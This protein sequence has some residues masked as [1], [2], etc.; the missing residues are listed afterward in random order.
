MSRIIIWFPSEYTDYSNLYYYKGLVFLVIIYVNTFHHFFSRWSEYYFIIYENYFKF[1]YHYFIYCKYF[2]NFLD[3]NL[4]IYYYLDFCF[5]FSF[6]FSFKDKGS[7]IH[8]YWVILTWIFFNPSKGKIV[9]Y[10]FTGIVSLTFSLL[11][12][13]FFLTVFVWMQN[14]KGIVFLYI[15][16]LTEKN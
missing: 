5:Y 1:T 6:Y 9:V 8:I 16:L 3:P 12:N 13:V 15:H 14:I 2:W 11:K 7:R 4:K 10:F